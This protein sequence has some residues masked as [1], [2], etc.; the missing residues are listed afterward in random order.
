[1]GMGR[2]V[3]VVGFGEEGVVQVIPVERDYHSRSLDMKS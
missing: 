2:K 3:R 1:M